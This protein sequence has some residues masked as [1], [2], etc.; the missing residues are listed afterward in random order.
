VRLAV[1]SF[2]P[3]LRGRKVLLHED[4]QAV[5]IVLGCLT[6]R[7]LAMMDN[8]RKIW[9]LIDTNHITIRAR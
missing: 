8:T 5:V 6:S 3:L 1:L 7:S 2:L 9:E 4:N